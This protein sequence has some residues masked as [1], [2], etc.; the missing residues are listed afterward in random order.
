M[1]SVRKQSSWIAL[2]A[3]V[4]MTMY[5]GH[6]S[7]A[8]ESSC[9]Q[10]ASIKESGSSDEGKNYQASES[11]RT[12]KGTV[13][14]YDD[15]VEVATLKFAGATIV[16][17]RHFVACD[18]HGAGMSSLRMASDTPNGASPANSAAWEGDTCGGTDAKS[19]TFK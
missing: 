5:A 14:R 9:P 4:L 1:I 11:G 8:G 18:Y 16:N 10:V 3:M 12:W 6:A 2:M 15:D 17:S 13:S 7:A 19:C